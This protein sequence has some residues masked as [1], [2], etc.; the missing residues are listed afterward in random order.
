MGFS[1]NTTSFIEVIKEKFPDKNIEG[2]VT[3]DDEYYF[4][5]NF[6]SKHKNLIELVIPSYIFKLF[7]F[8]LVSSR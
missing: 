6:D 8:F 3:L 2:G 5:L 7:D 4:K 1:N